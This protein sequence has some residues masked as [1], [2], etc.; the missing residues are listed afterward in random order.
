MSLPSLFSPVLASTNLIE[1]FINCDPAGQIITVGLA[2]F[3]VIA[4][5]IMLQK[6]YELKR[7]ATYNHAFESHLRDLKLL[8]VTEAGPRDTGEV[9]W[10][11]AAGDDVCLF[12][13]CRRL[14]RH[15][16]GQ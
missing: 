12:Y 8:I 1:V 9:R 13:H 5:T 10:M 15:S 16:H 4:W 2:V 11:G 7:L 14:W 6:H 3:S